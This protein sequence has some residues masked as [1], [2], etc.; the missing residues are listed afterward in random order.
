M[1]AP[2]RPRAREDLDMVELD[3]EALIYD[4]RAERLHH[5]NPTATVVFGLCDGG[6]TVPELSEELAHAYGMAGGEMEREVRRLLHRFRS[7]GLL[8]EARVGR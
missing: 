1:S 4:A 7:A 3:G 2:I 5:L 6:S 8:Q